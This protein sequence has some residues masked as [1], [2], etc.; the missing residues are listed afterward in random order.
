M[1]PNATITGWRQRTGNDG[2]GQPT[3]TTRT[4][5]G[6]CSV[7]AEPKVTRL[8]R[9]GR[10]VISSLRVHVASGLDPGFAEGDR[11]TVSAGGVGVEYQVLE[12]SPVPH[13][14]LGHTTLLL[15]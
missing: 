11:I 9:Q 1:I 2:F 7:L 3:Y 5:S 15:A 8:K 4:L 14:T 13:P 10:E 12:I 6:V